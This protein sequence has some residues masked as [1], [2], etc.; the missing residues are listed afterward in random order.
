MTAA[1]APK[2]AGTPAAPVTLRRPVACGTCGEPFRPAPGWLIFPSTDG[3]LCPDCAEEY[4]ER[5][6]RELADEQRR[7][8]ARRV[9][10]AAEVVYLGG[11]VVGLALLLVGFLLTPPRS[12]P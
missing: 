12:R 11:L 3:A 10:R 7:A 4:R 2:R 1:R 8:V 9:T 5:R 6:V